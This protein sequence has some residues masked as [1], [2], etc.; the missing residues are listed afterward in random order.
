M[1]AVEELL[2]GLISGRYSVGEILTFC[3][4]LIFSVFAFRRLSQWYRL[5]HIPGPP[6]AGFSRLVWLAPLGLSGQY[7]TWMRDIN[8]KYGRLVRVGPKTVVTSDWR[9]WKRIM[10]ARSSWTKSDRYTGFRLDPQRD[11]IVSTLDEREHA[12]LRYIM[13]HGY[14]GKEVVGVEEKLDAEILS[15]IRLLETSYIA[16]NKPFDFARKVQ[17]FTTDAIAH[18]VFGKPFGFLETDSDVYSYIAIIEKTMPA[19]SFFTNFPGLLRLLRLPVLNRLLPKPTDKEGIGRLMGL[20][21][22]AAAERFGPDRKVQKDM[23]GSFIA[24]GLT[25]PEA[26]TQIMLQVVAGSDTS[27][28]AIRSAMLNIATNPLVLRKLQAEIDSAAP[29]PKVKVVDDATAR[30]LPYLAATIRESLRW[31]QPTMDMS[32]KK[33]PPEGDEWDGYRLPGGTEVGWNSICVMRDPELWG[34]DAEQFRPERWIEA[35]SDSSKLRDME[36][37]VEL[38]F[39]GGSRYQCLGRAVALMEIRKAIFELFRRYEF[40]V[41]NAGKPWTSIEWNMVE[42]HGFWL[43]A[44]P[45][46]NSPSML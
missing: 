15:F 11:H 40:V 12:R 13:Q 37:V 17:Y 29:F 39:A 30:N 2:N 42:Q 23:L 35:A 10:S 43:K 4:L 26:E 1:P 7:T 14:S 31:L 24:R 44:Y 20:A 27:A 28:T 36:Y 25:Q 22:E 6:L 38:N 34:D 8:R 21:R 32:P 16:C 18:L 45:R 33:A 41:I 19:M 5:S 3:S 46:E 9:L